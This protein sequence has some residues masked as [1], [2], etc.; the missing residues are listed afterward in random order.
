MNGVP[1]HLA[2]YKGTTGK[3]RRK[4]LKERLRR[5]VPN[6]QQ[7]AAVKAILEEYVV[8]YLIQHSEG[9]NNVNHQCTD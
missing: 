1:R 2:H 6:P 8:L 9:N 4:A 7:Y 3:N 5:E